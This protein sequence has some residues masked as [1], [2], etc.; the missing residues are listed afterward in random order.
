ME[1][2]SVLKRQ[3]VFCHETKALRYSTLQKSPIEFHFFLYMK[4]YKRGYQYVV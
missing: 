4:Y 2:Q 3:I 1:Q